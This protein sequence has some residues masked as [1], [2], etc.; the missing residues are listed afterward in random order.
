[1]NL[2]AIALRA[3]QAADEEAAI[4]LWRRSWQRAYPHIDFSARLG[5]WRERWRNELVP[6]CAIMLAEA[7]GRGGAA[8]D[9]TA[10]TAADRTAELAGFVTVDPTTGY[11]DQIVV[12][13]E[14]W[15]SPVAAALIGAAKR[16]APCGLDLHVNRD[17]ARAIR[18]YEKHGFAISG[19][20][21]NP[22]SGAP[23]YKMSWREI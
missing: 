9:R 23:L 19:E 6:A 7:A 20:D 11:L 12:A 2:D 10:E 13:P 5:W 18:F 22:R 14:A 15:G 17:N 8:A 1:V 3:Y 16:I 21:A 4:A